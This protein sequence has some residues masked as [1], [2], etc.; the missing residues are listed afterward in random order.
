ML[1]LSFLLLI[2]M[3][4]IARRFRSTF[5][6]RLHLLRHGVLGMVEILNLKTKKTKA[7]PV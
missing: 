5:T 4:L 7:A 1:A 6:E 2:G 3:T